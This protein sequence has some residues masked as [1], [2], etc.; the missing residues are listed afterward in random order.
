MFYYAIMAVRQNNKVEYIHTH[1]THT[2]ASTEKQKKS[3]KRTKLK[4]HLTL[5][6]VCKRQCK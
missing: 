4:T 1:T 3:K 6:F 5:L 2:N